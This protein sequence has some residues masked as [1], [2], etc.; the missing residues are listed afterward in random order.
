LT[1]PIASRITLLPPFRFRNGLPNESPAAYASNRPFFVSTPRPNV[2]HPVPYA[3]SSAS[4]LCL[5]V[6]H[7]SLPDLFPVRNYIL[8]PDFIIIPL[9]V[10][11]QA[12]DS[13]TCNGPCIQYGV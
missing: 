8:I 11:R 1:G 4:D 9:P 3:L 13:R 12:S 6:H 5:P 7:Y 10:R 2:F